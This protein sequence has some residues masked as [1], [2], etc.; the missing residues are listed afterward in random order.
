MSISRHQLPDEGWADLRAMDEVPERLRR[1][2][3]TIQMKLAQNPAF[4]E[5]VKSA[6][7]SGVTAL[8]DI[9]EAKAVQMATAMGD[10]ALQMMDDL[11]DR[12]IISRVAGWSYGGEITL[13][14]LQ[15]LPGKVYDKLKE[16]CAEGA[17]DGGPDFSPSTE[18]DSP[19]EPSTASA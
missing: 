15:D 3:R 18:A 17:L 16:I 1:P 9:D 2:V 5:V 8:Q 12:L 6:Q 7:G 11:N 4:A 14:A 19:T 10:D 13:D